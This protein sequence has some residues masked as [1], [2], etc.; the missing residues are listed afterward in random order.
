MKALIDLLTWEV[1]AEPQPAAMP[2]NYVVEPLLPVKC[3]IRASIIDRN[4]KGYP[5]GRF[6]FFCQADCSLIGV[7][8]DVV[9]GDHGFTK[10]I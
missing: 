5:T 7:W 2:P 3:E 1:L 10:L 9:T 4:L 6:I 8:V